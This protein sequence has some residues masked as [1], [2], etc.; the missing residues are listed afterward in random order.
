MSPSQ[1]GPGSVTRGGVPEMTKGQVIY[2]DIPTSTMLLTGHK[3]GH[4]IGHRTGHMTVTESGKRTF[5]QRTHFVKVSGIPHTMVAGTA[6]E[7]RTAGNVKKTVTKGYSYSYSL[8][9][10]GTKKRNRGSDGVTV[11]LVLDGPPP[12]S[13]LSSVSQFQSAIIADVFDTHFKNIDD[14]STQQVMD[15]LIELH[16]ISDIDVFYKVAAIFKKEP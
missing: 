11:P 3:I 5:G 6:S 8:T 2:H 1:I 10:A 16:A 14:I 9:A 12:V 4:M 15:K 7:V 13:V